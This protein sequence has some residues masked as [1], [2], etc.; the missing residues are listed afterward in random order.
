MKLDNCN[1]VCLIPSYLLVLTQKMLVNTE[2]LACTEYCILSQNAIQ[3]ICHFQ[4]RFCANALTA[5]TPS[6]LYIKVSISRQVSSDGK[7]SHL[8]WVSSRETLTHRWTARDNSKSFQNDVQHLCILIHISQ[9]IEGMV[10]WCPD[11]NWSLSL[12]IYM[13]SVC[14]YYVSSRTQ[15]NRYVSLLSLL[16][17]HISITSHVYQ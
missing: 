14:L 16:L 10:T 6:E 8:A 4:R 1:F 9:M 12:I 13:C 3:C 15:K 17:E 5:L 11:C 2:E 7:I